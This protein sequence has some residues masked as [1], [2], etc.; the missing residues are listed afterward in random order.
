MDRDVLAVLFVL[1][2]FGLAWFYGN[3]GLAVV[4]VLVGIGHVYEKYKGWGSY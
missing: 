3:A 4:G 1:F 2:I